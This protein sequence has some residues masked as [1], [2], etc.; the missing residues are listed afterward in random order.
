MS[1]RIFLL[2]L[3]CSSLA[4]ASTP[5]C[6]FESDAD[7]AAIRWASRAGDGALNRDPAYASSG[8]FSLRFESP[9]WSKGQPEWPAFEWAPA[10]RDWRAYDRLVVDLVNPG[11]ATPYLA[12][13]VSDGK[14]P[15]REGMY[16]RFEVPG[17]GFRR[18]VI[19]LAAFP[20]RVNR[21]E[22][23]VIHIYT[24]RPAAAVRLHLDQITLLKPGEALPD[25]PPPF[26]RQMAAL[27]AG[28]VA[29]AGQLASE[30]LAKVPN[31]PIRKHLDGVAAKA[32][33]ITTALEAGPKDLATLE[34]M[35]REARALPG[36][37][38]RWLA[39]HEFQ[40]VCAAT[41]QAADGLLVGHATSM[42]K[43]LPRD[44]PFALRPEIRVSISAA[45]YEKESFQ[46]VVVPVSD[47]ARRVC[48]TARDLKDRAGAVLSG[49]NIRCD[50][51]GYVKT[52]S[53][54]PYGSSHVGWWPDPILDFLGPVDI[55][56]GDLQSFW[57]RVCVP[58]SQRPG[59]YN[60]YLTISA[61][62]QA[63]IRV[64]LRVTVR[65]FTLPKQSPLPVAITFSPS[66]HPM[67]E[68][69]DAQAEWRKSPE[70]PVNAWRNHKLRWADF[71][72]DYY[73]N[74]DNLY[75]HGPPDFEVLRHLHQQG[76]LRT[77]N[78]G[79]FDGASRDP[80]Q[81]AETLA[82]LRTAYGKAKDL[83]ILDKAYIY[84]FDE[85][86]PDQFPLLEKTA[87]TLRNEFP[88][89]LLM[90]TSYDHSYG[91]DTVV[92]TIDAWCPLTPKF[93]PVQAA[94]ARAAGK[95]VWWYIC[96]GPG[97][98]YA[99]MFIELPAI[100]GRLLMGAMTAKQRPDGFLYYQTSIW[101]SQ[102]PIT[103]GPF[104]EWDPRS[105]TTYHGDGSWA[106]VGPDGMPLPTIRL[107]N[108]RDG[109]EDYA[110][111][112]ILEEAL[113]AE[114]ADGA[115]SNPNRKRWLDETKAAL[116]V[117]AD[118][119]RSMTEYSRD[120][121]ELNAWRERLGDLIELSGRSDVNP[122][123]DGRK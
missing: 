112:R 96:C 49:S 17:R 18:C 57:I 101:N 21:A 39:L 52:G 115:A 63:D 5:V 54:P 82:G 120:P 79:I 20:D 121:A 89:T 71:L 35:T 122:W 44:A 24:E 81:A 102:K 94:K 41:G 118:L 53:V 116:E 97:R 107:E 34:A 109:L 51:V 77:F 37:V 12:M 68:T 25:P 61:E 11:E 55:A 14:V 32:R 64:P 88:G 66:D 110:Y 50:V 93:D 36:R 6:D 3:F 70:Y 26:L 98:P 113:R 9:A 106:C 56:P 119:V 46:L 16:H 90:T 84:G 4:R 111:F 78:L 80:A 76:R 58:E 22:I 69:A 103:T 99:N 8:G 7:L 1:T 29:R 105:W 91:M 48:V 108:F 15:F 67:P 62:G 73:I 104:T 13:F 123:A 38:E 27:E 28:Q 42:E 10:V 2:A 23:S 31:G 65:G 59:I 114:L 40:K 86:Q 83:G 30:A 85:C 43:I 19:P 72:A 60:G 45:R 47:V 75:R 92:K 95:Q 74:F 100:E 117:P 87:R 33:E